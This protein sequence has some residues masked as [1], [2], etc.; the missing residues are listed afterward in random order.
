MD[1]SHPD[2]FAISINNS[3]TAES[4]RSLVDKSVQRDRA[5]RIC[6][7]TQRSCG[8][9]QAD[10]EK[11]SA[12][13]PVLDPLVAAVVQLVEPDV[14]AGVGRGEG[15]DGDRDEAQPEEA[16]PARARCRAREIGSRW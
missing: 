12:K 13:S 4:V 3:G 9:N 7:C 2:A 14:L 6:C 1:L 5:G 11:D 16:F 8:D 15:P 10:A